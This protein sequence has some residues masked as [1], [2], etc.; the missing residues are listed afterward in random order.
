MARQVSPE[1]V[2]KHLAAMAEMGRRGDAFIDYHRAH[3]LEGTL[4]WC[5]NPDCTTRSRWVN[6]KRL[7]SLDF[8]TVHIK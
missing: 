1:A 4:V 6:G 3:L 2:E 7:H 5:S 8:V